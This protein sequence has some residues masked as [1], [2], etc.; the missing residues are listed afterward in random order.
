[1]LGRREISIQYA[2]NLYDTNVRIGR[3]IRAFF[4]HPLPQMPAAIRTFVDV[5][6]LRTHGVHMLARTCA[7]GLRRVVQHPR[8]RLPSRAHKQPHD[9]SAFEIRNTAGYVEMQMT[10]T[11]AK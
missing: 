11:T 8:I 6:E 9:R 7:Q 4:A 1:M 3:W 5:F 2:N 10:V